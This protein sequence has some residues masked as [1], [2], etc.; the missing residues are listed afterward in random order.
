[1][2][3]SFLS[4]TTGGRILPEIIRFGCLKKLKSWGRRWAKV[5][6][7]AMLSLRRPARPARW[8]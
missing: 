5:S 4:V 6:T 7:K 1:M 3:F 8:T 2:I